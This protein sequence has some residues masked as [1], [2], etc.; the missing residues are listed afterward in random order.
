MKYTAFFVMLLFSTQSWACDPDVYRHGNKSVYYT[1]M[2]LH[3]DAKRQTEEILLHSGG[4][5]IPIKY[6]KNLN[7]KEYLV[8]VAHLYN[9]NAILI[10]D[11]LYR[12]DCK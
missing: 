3:L 2:V 5:G 4:T 6:G 1:G 7:K 12:P 10:N 11:V 8:E 9:G